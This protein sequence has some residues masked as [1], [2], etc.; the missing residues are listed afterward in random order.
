MKIGGAS[1][2]RR[3]MFKMGWKELQRL[4]IVPISSASRSMRT[5][6]SC[7][8]WGVVLKGRKLGR[9]CKHIPD[10]KDICRGILP[11]IMESIL[12]LIPK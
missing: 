6:S 3:I 11:N 7:D 2:A 12:E 8:L 9:T 5:T 10:I 4:W 1:N